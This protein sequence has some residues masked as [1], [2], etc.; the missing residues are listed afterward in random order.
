VDVESRPH[1]LPV[2]RV[3]DRRPWLGV[4]HT[5]LYDQIRHLCD[6]SR[7]AFVVVDAT[8]PDL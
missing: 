8:N 5:T 4:R 6:H 1:D 2:Y 3:V 7:A